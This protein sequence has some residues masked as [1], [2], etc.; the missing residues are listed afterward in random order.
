MAGSYLAIASCTSALTKKSG[1][2][3][4]PERQIC[5]VLVL[6]GWGVLGDT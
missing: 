4:Y 1:N 3:F 6:L 5:L 2:Q